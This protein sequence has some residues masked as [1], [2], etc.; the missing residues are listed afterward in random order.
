MPKV[1]RRRPM[2]RCF[3]HAFTA[4]ETC[5]AFWSKSR[6]MIPFDVLPLAGDIRL[7]AQARLP[8]TDRQSVRVWEIWKD[9]LARCKGTLFDGTLLEFVDFVGPISHRSARQ[10]I[11]GR[12]VNYREYLASRRE[13]SL[14]GREVVPISVSGL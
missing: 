4:Y 2:C 11:I 9:E 7:T 14:L 6:P 13:P 5:A 10:T 12:F 1:R 3:W 8:L